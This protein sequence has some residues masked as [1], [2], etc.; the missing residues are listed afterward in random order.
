MTV[1]EILDSLDDAI[2][3]AWNLPLTGGRCIVE[4]EKM[5]ELINDVRLALPKE[6]KQ[7][8]M[9][10][11]DRQDII[12]DARNEA[13]QIINDAEKKAQRLVS[14][15]EIVRRAKEKAN[16]MLTNAHTQSTAL[17]SSTNE[18]VEKLLTL[19]ENA[20]AKNLQ[21]LKASHKQIMKTI[22]N[23]D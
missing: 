16:Q 22:N 11:T 20:L 14:E 12:N 19:S 18:Y 15:T 2:E 13:K 1:N 23:K 7:A 9:I 5:L 3:S 21:E 10:V 17:K 4:V 8:K 6:L